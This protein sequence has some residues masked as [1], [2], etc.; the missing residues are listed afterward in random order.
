MLHDDINTS[1]LVVYDQYI[2]R[3]KLKIM[4]RDV[5]R[6]RFDEQGQPRLNKRDLNQDFSSGPK[7]KQERGG[8]SQVAKPTFNNYIEKHFGKYLD[9]TNRFNGCG[10][11]HPKVKDFPTLST[12]RRV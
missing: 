6:S 4:N 3:W 9:G 11:N 1:R 7:D 5:K 2:D 10:K 12:R 8:K